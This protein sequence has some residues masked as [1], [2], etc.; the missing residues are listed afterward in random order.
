MQLNDMNR[1]VQDRLPLDPLDFYIFSALVGK[2]LH[3]YEIKKLVEAEMKKT[4]PTASLYRRLRTMREDNL[5]EEVEPPIKDDDPR[6]QYF[7][8]TAFGQAVYAAEYNRMREL[9]R[10]D[11]GV[12]GQGQPTPVGGG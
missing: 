6:R 4:V 5:I 10:K 12:V 3:G 11:S 8:V 7:K 1:Q 9:V 2:T